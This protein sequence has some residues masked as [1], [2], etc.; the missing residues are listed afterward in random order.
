MNRRSALTLGGGAAALA[1]A[2]ALWLALR[3]ASAPLVPAQWPVLP[4]HSL[5][6][7]PQALAAQAP[8]PRLINLW[9]RWC[10]PCRRE[11]PSLQRL[12]TRLGAQH[13]EV[14][15]LAVEEDPFALREYVTALRLALPVWRL[16]PAESLR[17]EASGTLPQTWLV[18]P[19]GRV[20]GR[21]PGERDWDQPALQRQLMALADTAPSTGRGDARP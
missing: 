13:I 6:G 18:A 17:L 10:A 9:A 12:A 4:V 2:A 14:L 3:P 7:Q 11:L 15:A 16:A 20:L 8:T 5:T 19:S 21:W 1:G